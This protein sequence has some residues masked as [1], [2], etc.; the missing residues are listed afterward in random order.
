MRSWD[1]GQ[2]SIYQKDIAP[3]APAAPDPASSLWEPVSWLLPDF[4]SLRRLS[5]TPRD[6]SRLSQ[7]LAGEGCNLPSGPIY[8][9]WSEKPPLHQD[10]KGLDTGF[11]ALARHRAAR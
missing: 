8:K 4:V 3:R 5:I 9:S 1:G 6:G 7:G 10:S 2:P 11:S